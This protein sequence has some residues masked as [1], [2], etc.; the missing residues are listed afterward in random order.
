MNTLFFLTLSIGILLLITLV[1][2]FIKNYYD[3]KILKLNETPFT[4]P[5]IVDWELSNLIK[6][7]LPCV[8]FA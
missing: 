2:F 4:V 8:S 3:R 1:A 5:E 7:K 6:D